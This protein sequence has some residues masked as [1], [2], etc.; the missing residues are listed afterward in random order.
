VKILPEFTHTVKVD[1]WDVDDEGMAVWRVSCCGDE[2][3]VEALA[4]TG[5][6][7]IVGLAA[8]AEEE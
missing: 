5:V 2:R 8:I 7:A 6:W 3:Y 1:M 4:T